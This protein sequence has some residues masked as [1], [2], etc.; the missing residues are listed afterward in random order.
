MTSGNWARMAW[1]EVGMVEAAEVEEG[2]AAAAAAGAVACTEA[3]GS[4]GRRIAA[5][6]QLDCLER[7]MQVPEDEAEMWPRAASSRRPW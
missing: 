5:V 6:G 2:A 3:A 4:S 1:K 7:G